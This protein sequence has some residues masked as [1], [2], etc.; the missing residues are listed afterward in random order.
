MKIG[1]LSFGKKIEKFDL[2]TEARRE[3]IASLS[4]KH[5]PDILLCAGW[6]VET[7]DDIQWLGSDVRINGGNTS[8]ILEVQRDKQDQQDLES[9]HVMYLI[10]PKGLN[11]KL[12]RQIF[13]SSDQLNEDKANERLLKFAA[14]LPNRSVKVRNHELFALCCG[15]LNILKG[16]NQVVC[17]SPAVASAIDSADIIVNPT[18]DL[19]GNA[20]TLIAKREYLS[21][22]IEGRDRVYISSSN[23]DHA[24]KY[25]DGRQRKKQTQPSHTLQTVFMNGREK[26]CTEPSESGE[27]YEYRGW[28]I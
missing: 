3:L 24:G 2:P 20:G 12:G 5:K 28:D 11:H 21:R 27:G 23:W 16:R 17:R 15:E 7:A 4:E 26:K 22:K 6:S 13:A 10:G 9:D 1:T 14:C 18:H 25:G 19:M 8:I